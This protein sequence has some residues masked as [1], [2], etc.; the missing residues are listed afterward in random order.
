MIFYLLNSFIPLPFT[1]GE[2]KLRKLFTVTGL[3]QD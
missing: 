2:T 1:L 3:T